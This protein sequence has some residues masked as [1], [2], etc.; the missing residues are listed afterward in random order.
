METK[1]L[2][3]FL[4]DM[5]KN[6]SKYPPEL[7]PGINHD[8]DILSALNV[9]NDIDL[10]DVFYLLKHVPH[11]LF[12]LYH[13]KFPIQD[14]KSVVI[15]MYPHRR[16]LSSIE[17]LLHYTKTFA[18]TLGI[19][20]TAYPNYAMSEPMRQSYDIN[21]W[22]ASV[23]Q[24]YSLINQGYS[25]EQS[26]EHVLNNWEIGESM[27]FKK[28]LSFWETN[29]QN[30]YKTAGM[31]ES[32]EVPGLVIPN[33]IEPQHLK[34]KLP[35]PKTVSKLPGLA[36][37][38]VSDVRTRVEKQ[39]SKLVS[40]LNAAEKMLASMDG[41]LFAGDDQELML[42]LLQDL[43]RKI[44]TSNKLSTKSSL[45]ED[46]IHRTAN[47]LDLNNKPK[48]AS[49]FRKIA[50][51]MNFPL[52]DMG[53]P[54]A[55]T[56][57]S[58]SPFGAPT[59]TSDGTSGDKQ[60]TYDF[61]QEFFNNLK[62]G[63]SSESDKERDKKKEQE[64][65][66]KLNKLEKEPLPTPAPAPAPVPTNP[67]TPEAKK[68]KLPTP[69]PANPVQAFFEDEDELVVYAQDV[70]EQISEII[71]ETLQTLRNVIAVIDLVHIPN[72]KNYASIVLK[73]IASSEFEYNQTKEIFDNII[74]K[75]F[76][77]SNVLKSLSS[78]LNQMFSNKDGLVVYAQDFSLP[79]GT[80]TN[81][82]PKHTQDGLSE[83]IENALNNVTVND[84]IRELD[85]VIS[86]LNQREMPNKL[87]YIDIALNKLG[88]SSFFPQIGEAMGKINESTTYVSTRL[89]TVAT[90][91]KGSL[92]FSGAN[93]L[94]TPQAIPPG[95]EGIH[96]NLQVQEN[97]EQSAKETR[98]Q[99]E[100][101]PKTQPVGQV[102][103]EL[104]EPARIEQSPL[105]EVR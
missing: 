59:P 57:G 95:S 17:K 29:Q 94:T 1:L 64:E 19:N 32:P 27:S 89:E 4:Q 85:I 86:V 46:F 91:L 30:K 31:Y 90:K 92:H 99:K 82:I 35:I 105:I 87:S 48:G 104:K 25:R 81:P 37:N 38:D 50:Q 12:E 7:F 24:I 51:D 60:P 88:L 22:I 6:I 40:R 33:I 47:L 101:Q 3:D 42:R 56:G 69:P 10:K 34:A 52:P 5:V 102:A 36:L 23:K 78:V 97:K 65:D 28:W 9:D 68:S 61:L 73:K 84:V 83:T 55:P 70:P 76:E 74:N 79:T 44:Q 14:V 18:D 100:F 16:D 80:K 96:Q 63:L 39:R 103:P 58:A 2:N 43:K 93:E 53:A 75:S 62:R 15:Q 20:K 54:S 21:K 11:A 67:E 72:Q 66:Q 49:F 45:F 8:L 98:K 41:Q 71:P 13:K 77:I 26:L